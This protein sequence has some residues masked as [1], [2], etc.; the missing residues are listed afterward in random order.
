MDAIRQMRD[1]L[2]TFML[3][4]HE[5]SAAMM[6]WAMYEMMGSEQLMK[7]VRDLSLLYV[8]TMIVSLGYFISLTFLQH[9]YYP[10][11]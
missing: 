1:E 3:A 2:K 11:L 5:T 7:E 4:G 10:T 8:Q 9:L 6:T